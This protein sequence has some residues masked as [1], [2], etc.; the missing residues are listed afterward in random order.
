MAAA[1]RFDHDLPAELVRG[2][3][4]ARGIPHDDAVGHRDPGR[5]EQLLGQALVGGDVDADGGSLAGKRRA[6]RALIHPVAEPEQA[7]VA[8]P[9]RPRGN[10]RSVCA[11]LT[12][13]TSAVGVDIA[14]DKNL[15][16]QMLAAAGIP[17]P[18]AIVVWE[19]GRGAAEAAERLGGHVVVKPLGG[20]HGANLT[21][22]VRSAAQAE[23]AYVKAA[24]AAE[25]VLVEAFLPGTDYRVLII[26]GRVAA[27]AQLR[28]G[29]G[30]R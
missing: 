9:A 15:S 19:R 12:S 4:R 14:A 20:N 26:D 21:I 8:D 7:A 18:E 17:V 16:K 3:G 11:A 30:D 5:R 29:R 22:G 6:H 1:E 28:P 10:A 2:R 13:Q 23:A 24:A 27:A 25:A